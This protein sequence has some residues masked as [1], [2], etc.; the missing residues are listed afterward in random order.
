[1]EIHCFY[2]FSKA[3]LDVFLRF[4]LKFFVSLNWSHDQHNWNC[5]AKHALSKQVLGN[6]WELFFFY[7]RHDC[8]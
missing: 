3:H 8:K 6:F 1:M 7:L 4:Y 2:A 5:I